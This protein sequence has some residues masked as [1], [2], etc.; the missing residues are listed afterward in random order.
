MSHAG[1]EKVV[2]ACGH[3]ERQCR[4]M[5]PK[6]EVRLEHRCPACSTMDPKAAAAIQDAVLDAVVEALGAQD[7]IVDNSTLRGLFLAAEGSLKQAQEI[8]DEEE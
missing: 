2:Y 5:G 8:L 3:V 1:H 4:C 6:I 7:E